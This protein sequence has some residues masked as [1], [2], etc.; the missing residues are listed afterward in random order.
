M[1]EGRT[2]VSPQLKHWQ[3]PIDSSPVTAALNRLNPS[4]LR[5]THV[6][7]N[8]L[9]LSDSHS[10]AAFFF[11]FFGLRSLRSPGFLSSPLSGVLEVAR[12]SWSAGGPTFCQS[13][14]NLNLCKLQRLKNLTFMTCWDEALGRRSFSRSLSLSLSV[15]KSFLCFPPFFFLFLPCPTRSVLSLIPTLLIYF[16][17]ISLLLFQFSK[18]V[19]TDPL[20]KSLDS[21]LPPSAK[22]K[23]DIYFFHWAKYSKIKVFF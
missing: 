4:R 23:Y 18:V 14:L 10:S 15:C 17:L 11:L 21:L 2:R 8:T 7:P 6:H 1:E 9:E 16:S 13:D 19:Q 3:P 12:M 22:M 5:H 20:P